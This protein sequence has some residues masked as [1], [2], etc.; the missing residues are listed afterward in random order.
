MKIL[1]HYIAPQIL[2]IVAVDFALA[3]ISL[4]VGYIVVRAFGF[5]AAMPGGA[6]LFARSALFAVAVNGGI[7]ATGLYSIQQRYRAAAVVARM[8]IGIGFAAL[9]IAVLDFLLRFTD[10]RPVWLIALG[11]SAILLGAARTLFTRHIDSEIFRRRVV[12]YGAGQRASRILELRRRSD[13][14]G[15][16][17]VAFLPAEGDACV[18]DDDRVMLSDACP[19]LDYVRRHGVSEIVVAADDR[20]RGLPVTDLLACKLSGIRVVD[21]LEF[22]ERETG[23]LKVDMVSPG[24]VIFSSGFA[25]TGRHQL[26]FRLL[27]LAVAGTLALLALPVAAIVVLAILLDDGRAILYRQ[28]RV[29]LNGKEFVLYKFRSMRKDAEAGRGACWAAKNDQRVT[30]VG[31]YLRKYRL[32]ELPQLVNVLKGDMSVVGPRPERPEFVREL[33]STI[34]YYAERHCVKP[35]LTGWAQLC[36][37]YG[38]CEQDARAKLEYDMYYVKNRSLAFNFMILLRTAEV[39]LWQKGSR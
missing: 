25:R 5:A 26:S 4:Y 11:L 16:R 18:V 8:L 30:R 14:R 39:V 17:V 19:I 13:Q 12:V 28:R 7:A 20:R 22:L 33:S 31:K 35:G 34:P 32:D 21:L 6:G 23:R 24:W 36:Y 38:D 15:F 10:S 9:A 3:I 2:L 37:P 27:D 1:T 29:G